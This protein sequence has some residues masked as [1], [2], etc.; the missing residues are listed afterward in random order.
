[1]ACCGKNHSFNCSCGFG[2][3]AYDSDELYV[4]TPPNA[5]CRECNAWVYFRRSSNGGGTYF[6]SLQN[7]KRHSCTDRRWRYSPF[8]NQGQPKL[9]NKRTRRQQRGF[10]PVDVREIRE[11][12]GNTVIAC[13]WMSVPTCF[14]ITFLG[15][16]PLDTTRNVSLWRREGSKAKIL[17]FSSD[18]GQEIE[19]SV[20]FQAV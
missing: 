18:T 20:A 15:S 16:I 8:N 7:W 1:M 14:E 19:A 13:T 5:Q 4:L 10:L 9:R 6:D 3:R 11:N 12:S 17:F 2:A